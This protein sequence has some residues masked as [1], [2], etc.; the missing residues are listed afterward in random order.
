[1][2]AGAN[3]S[4]S[5]APDRHD[6]DDDE[7]IG[8]AE[9]GNGWCGCCCKAILSHTMLGRRRQL[10]RE[11]RDIPKIV[12]TR[13]NASFPHQVYIVFPKSLAKQLS[14]LQPFLVEQVVN[15][16]VAAAIGLSTINYKPYWTYRYYELVSPREQQL[17]PQV[18]MY[19][20][21]ALG[22]VSAIFVNARETY[23]REASAGNNRFAYYVG[24]VLSL[25]PRI[26]LTSII[27][28]TLFLIIPRLAVSFGDIFLAVW[29]I[30]GC[31]YALGII[32]ATFV[33]P[34]AAPLVGTLLAIFFSCLSGFI[35]KFPVGMKYLSCAYWASSM[36]QRYFQAPVAHAYAD[37][38][39]VARVKSV[40]PLLFCS[41]SDG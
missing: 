16:V 12:V 36:L 26:V 4:N 14:D 19:L 17:L 31:S 11:E 5:N 23:F 21:M 28:T 41:R 13:R 35:D 25:Q 20:C 37:N 18:F 7:D 10:W 8:R 30:C 32:P 24:M 1:M 39:K 34:S 33:S 22:I 38:V 9:S 27:F 40:P 6:G 15:V 2:R 29:F 3:N